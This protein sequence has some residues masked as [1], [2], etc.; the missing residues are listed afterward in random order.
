MT[1]VEQLI[2]DL[3]QNAESPLYSTY[4]WV[5]QQ[6]GRDVSLSEF[7]QVAS[8]AV[9]QDIVRLWSVDSETGDRTEL[10]DV[11][12]NL[13]HRYATESPLDTQYDPCGMSLSLG[14]AADSVRDPEWE[15]QLDFE[16]DVFRISARS[17]YEPKALDELA[18]C[19]PDLRLSVTDREEHGGYCRVDGTMKNSVDPA[20]DAKVADATVG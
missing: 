12:P 17:G 3:V 6:L 9:E 11:P 18:R 8:R 2:V 1:G 19:Y 5:G 15:F 10:Y 4:R 16:N 7:L 14:S 20:T 13:E